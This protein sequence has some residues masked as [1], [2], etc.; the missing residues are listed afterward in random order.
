MKDRTKRRRLSKA[1]YLITIL[2][3]RQRNDP[4]PYNVPRT[5][6]TNDYQRTAYMCKKSLPPLCGDDVS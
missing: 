3:L 1:A 4:T 5:L 6:V 2:L